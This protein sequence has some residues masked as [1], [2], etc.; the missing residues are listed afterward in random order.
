M[1]HVGTVLQ[2][3]HAAA[4]IVQYNVA[5]VPEAHLTCMLT[6]AEEAIR[7]ILLQKFVAGYL[8]KCMWQRPPESVLACGQCFRE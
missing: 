3:A 1:R 7:Q 5:A 4:S 6:G 8:L 2:R